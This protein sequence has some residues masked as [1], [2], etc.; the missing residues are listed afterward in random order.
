M[1]ARL[2]TKVGRPDLPLPFR[3]A[4]PGCS[5]VPRSKGDQDFGNVGL[6]LV[7]GFGSSHG[8]ALRQSSQDSPGWSVGAR[9]ANFEVVP[10]D[11]SSPYIVHVPHSSTR[12]PDDVRR[13]LLLSD[14]ALVRELQLMTDAH[15]DELAI[16]ASEQVS[17]RPWLFLNR[18]SRLV[19]DPER[20]PYG[21]EEMTDV[22]MGLVYTR[23]SRGG[24][25]RIPG[26]QAEQALLDRFLTPYAEALADLVDQ[27]LRATGYAVVVDL[28]S[29]QLQTLPYERHKDARRP[30]VCIG[31]DV[32][33][34]PAAL[35]ERVSSACS[36]IGEVVVN[37]PFSG[38]YIP[39]RHFGRDIRVASVMVELRRDT[40]LREDGSLDPEGTLRIT[41]ALV[42]ILR[43]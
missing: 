24:A 41:A 14:D 43:G 4:S 11:D 36:A 31:A 23:T 12:I 19:V 10:G 39:L 20:L 6:S 26:E 7:T 5:V 3:P 9:P 40:H 27:R 18:L 37:E 16:L 35:V 25:L 38:S 13:Q 22:G 33:H 15:T 28:H 1:P 29:Y 17:P 32:D 30:E 8:A 42:T 34:T 21:H 2:A